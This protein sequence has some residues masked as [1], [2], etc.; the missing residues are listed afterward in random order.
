MRLRQNQRAWKHTNLPPAGP[1]YRAGPNSLVFNSL[2][3]LQDIYL[4]DKVSKSRDYKNANLAPMSNVFTTLDKQEHRRKRKLIAP[5]INDRSMRTFEPALL[6]KTDVFAKQIL[7]ASQ[8]KTNDTVNMSQNCRYL[9]LDVVGLLSFGYDLKTQTEDTYRYLARI[10]TQGTWRINIRLHW[11]FFNTLKPEFTFI[12][13]TLLTGKGFMVVLKKMINA[14]LEVD[15]HAKHDL[16]AHMVHALDSKDEDE[17]TTMNE[18]WTEAIFFFPAGGDTSSTAMAGLFHYLARNPDCYRKLAEEI[19]STFES[20]ADIKGGTQ[21][22]SCRYLRACIDEALRM[23][24]PVSGV[25]WREQSPD[26]KNDFIVDGH[27]VPRGTRVGVSAYCI[28][29]NED[30]FPEPFKFE[31]ERWIPNENGEFNGRANKSAFIPFSA[32]ARSCAGKALAYLETSLVIAKAM[33]YFDFEFAPGYDQDK[34][35]FVLRD[36]FS[37]THEGPFLKFRPRGDA[38]KELEKVST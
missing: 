21:L 18:I 27:V 10:L 15:K 7:K 24:S 29:H 30:Y 34:D 6:E 14:R 22:N 1:V 12:I 31:P 13:R 32:G 36:I 16:Y 20:G 8:N 33:Y 9:G 23:S 38:W 5:V 3:A 37:A 4:N 26:D 11:P 19:R 28:H 25:L 17:K 35:E 2:T